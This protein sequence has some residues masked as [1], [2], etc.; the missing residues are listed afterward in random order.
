MLAPLGGTSSSGFMANS[1]KRL[2]DQRVDAWI[3]R[4]GPSNAGRFAGAGSAV[5][6]KRRESCDALRWRC[7][8][9]RRGLEWKPPWKALRRIS[10]LQRHEDVEARIA[11]RCSKIDAAEGETCFGKRRMGIEEW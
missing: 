7:F 2:D 1:P 4:G 5:V 3:C 11:T 10:N 6:A 8:Q 9:G